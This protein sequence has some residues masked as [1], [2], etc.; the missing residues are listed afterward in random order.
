MYVALC[1]LA[2]A[3]ERAAESKVV[4]IGFIMA[5]ME[6]DLPRPSITE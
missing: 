3:K 1:D 6:S 5:S 2:A 4:L